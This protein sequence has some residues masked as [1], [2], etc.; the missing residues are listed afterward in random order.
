MTITKDAIELLQQGRNVPA[1]I[2]APDGAIAVPLPAGY[3]LQRL[4]PLDRP[5]THTKQHVT[6]HDE[7]SLVA[8]LGTFKSE[9]SRL[10]AEP[11]FLSAVPGRARIVAAIDYH[12]AEG[13]QRVDHV[14]TYM[15]RYS[16]AWQRWHKACAQPL[17]QVELAEFI[18]ECRADIAEPDASGLIDM[19]RLFKASKKVE[20]DSVTY[21][22]DGRVKL[23]YSED[24]QKGGPAAELPEGLVLG[25]PVYYAGAA[26]KVP[27]FIRF[28]VGVGGVKFQLKL[29]RPD[30]IEDDAFSELVTRIAETTA[31]PHHIGRLGSERA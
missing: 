22:S 24:V 28:R 7:A 27:V 31:V 13:P 12:K 15:P 5:L 1:K 9:Q 3:T 25:I 18:E 26:Y 11:G 2:D 16:E 4:D 8:Y 21:Q 6:L 17:G 10:F 30:R 20:Y 14:A 19:V 29:D 23:H